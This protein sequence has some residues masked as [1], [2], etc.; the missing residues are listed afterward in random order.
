[1]NVISSYTIVSL[2]IL[3]AGLYTTGTGKTS[4]E[5]EFYSS[6]N[7]LMIQGTIEGN[8][9]IGPGEYIISEDIFI[10]PHAHLKIYP[11]TTLWFENRIQLQVAGKL[12]AIGD[13]TKSI[14]MAALPLEN[15]YRNPHTTDSL[16]EGI[17]IT[18]EGTAYFKYAQIRDAKYGIRTP[19]GCKQFILSDISF[20][21]IENKSVVLPD[22]SISP[23][24]KKII[25]LKYPQQFDDNY[26][27]S[28][29]NHMSW[30]HLSPVRKVTLGLFGA[31][32]ITFTSLA[33]M[34]ASKG[35]Q[36]S[37]KAND[38]LEKSTEQF[39]SD[40]TAHIPPFVYDPWAEKTMASR[41]NYFF[42]NYFTALGAA[43]AVGFVFSIPSPQGGK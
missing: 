38:H 43:C 17:I 6:I 25:S 30:K 23:S 42:M 28:N 31:G 27:I 33:L 36:N 7:K 20:S 26:T 41:R 21:N 8:V 22:E 16:W 12:E 5:E 9:E 34:E 4:K 37:D 29:Q 13:K 15:Y 2:L 19:N 24:N 39:P 32:I 40:F 11:G 35:K 3:F 18:E 1:L 14:E 10:A